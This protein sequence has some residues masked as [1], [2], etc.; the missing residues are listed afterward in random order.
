MQDSPG[1]DF[2]E[3]LDTIRIKK[4]IY[5]GTNPK[6]D[7]YSAF[8]DKASRNSTKLEKYLKKK[9]VTT[10]FFAG[11]ATNYCV[12]FSVLDSIDLGFRTYL[13]KNGCKGIELRPGDVERAEKEMEAA[14]ARLLRGV[15]IPG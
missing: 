2:P 11:L 10:L 5:K 15:D 7:S 13:I 1:S 4:I 9:K 14:G 12:K 3:R 8:F 6:F